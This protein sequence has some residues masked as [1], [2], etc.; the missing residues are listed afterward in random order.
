MAAMSYYFCSTIVFGVSNERFAKRYEPFIH[1]FVFAVTI[2]AAVSGLF[3]EVYNPK[4]SG[5]GCWVG[6]YPNG[7]KGEECI[8]GGAVSATVIQYLASVLPMCF[9]LF[10]IL[11]NNALIYCKVRKLE[12]RNRR[13][14]TYAQSTAAEPT[15][16]RQRFPLSI[17]SEPPDLGRSPAASVKSN[18]KQLSRKIATQS[19]CYV[20]AFLMSYGWGFLHFAFLSAGTDVVPLQ[21]INFFLYPAQGFF[22][23]IVYLRPNYLGWRDAGETRFKAIRKALFSLQSPRAQSLQRRQEQHQNNCLPEDDPPS[24]QGREPDCDTNVFKNNDTTVRDDD[25]TNLDG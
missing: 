5:M 12:V 11:I 15:A 14:S 13:Y 9:A 3:F 25:D 22:N 2:A 17:R 8:R 21:A 18:E 20:A 1:C 19:F 10:S 6:K 24:P 7:C 23:A 4:K 16:S